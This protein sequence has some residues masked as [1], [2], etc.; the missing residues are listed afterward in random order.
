MMIFNLDR[1]IVSS[2][3]KK[4]G[5]HGGMEAGDSKVLFS[6]FIGDWSFQTFRLKMF[7]REI[8]PENWIERKR[9]FIATSKLI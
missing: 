2:M 4:E 7:E 3:R 9:E 1:F 6:S 8:N 5:V